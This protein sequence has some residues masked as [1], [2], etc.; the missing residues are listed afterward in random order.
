VHVENA[1]TDDE[2]PRGSDDSD[3][4]V[5]HLPDDAGL[6]CA[7]DIYAV[8]GAESADAAGPNHIDIG[9]QPYD[10]LYGNDVVEPEAAAQS[11]VRRGI[12]ELDQIADSV[13]VVQLPYANTDIG[14][15]RSEEHTSELQ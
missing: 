15:A 13:A 3:L 9:R 14:A 8:V 5:I 2:V 7:S 4:G 10:T 12:T 1:D 11:E 6:E